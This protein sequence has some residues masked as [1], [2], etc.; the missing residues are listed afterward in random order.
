MPGFIEV[1]PTESD[2]KLIIN[3]DFIVL[4]TPHATGSRLSLSG[5]ASTHGSS[6]E[7]PY[8]T[9]LVAEPFGIICGLLNS[10]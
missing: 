7:S 10:F 8:H 6:L 9:L 3:V 4:V 2:Q 1:T 5:S